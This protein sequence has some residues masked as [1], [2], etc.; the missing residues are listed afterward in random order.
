MK[1]VTFNGLKVTPSKI[2]C[3]GRNYTKHIEELKNQDPK[4]IV[5]FIK[6]NSSIGDRIRVSDKKCRYEGEISFIFKDGYLEG[7][8]FGIDF[9][10]VEEQERLKKKG[11]PWE[12]SKAFDGSAVF[13][14]FVEISSFDKISMELWIN[15]QLRQKGSI[16]EMIYKPDVIV[17]EI[18]RYFT[19]YNYDILM[20]GTP[21][22]VG[23]FRKGDIFEGKILQNGKLLVQKEWIVE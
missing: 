9:T 7:V 21:S 18:K 14:D 6:P 15:G 13:S 2:F 11:L 10:L 20:C 19:P 23:S 17:S 16:S 5:L 12:K 1:T 22:G 8:G 4:E 3:V